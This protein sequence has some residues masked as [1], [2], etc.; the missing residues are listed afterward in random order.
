M[1]T[2]SDD[3]MC[4]SYGVDGKQWEERMR[5]FVWDGECSKEGLNGAWECTRVR[6]DEDVHMR[7]EGI[8]TLYIFSTHRGPYHIVHTSIQA[9]D[10]CQWL[11]HDSPRSDG[12]AVH[13]SHLV[14]HAP[15]SNLIFVLFSFHSMY[16]YLRWNQTCSYCTIVASETVHS[17]WH[18]SWSLCIL[19]SYDIHMVWYQVGK[20]H[21]LSPSLHTH[22][23]TL[24]SHM[25][26]GIPVINIWW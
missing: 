2:S 13:F 21:L 5:G 25:H 15:S 9:S 8:Y 18:C 3:G 7:G 17:H 11:L 20:D 10:H 4:W 24:I 26:T 22:E 14:L 23:H 19:S 16:R 1:A 12:E 6:K